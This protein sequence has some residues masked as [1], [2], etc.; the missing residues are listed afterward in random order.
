MAD[1]FIVTVTV[2]MA[3]GQSPAEALVVKVKITVPVVILG[4][5]VVVKAFGLL[6]MPVPTG[7]LHVALVAEP[8]IVPTKLALPPTQMV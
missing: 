2:L 7:A 6:N 3:A 8:P 4:V 5:N 1:E